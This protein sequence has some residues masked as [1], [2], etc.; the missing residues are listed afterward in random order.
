MI[1]SGIPPGKI[2][3]YVYPMVKAVPAAAW[4]SVQ[5]TPRQ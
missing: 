2:M 3:I 4:L 5:P 1:H